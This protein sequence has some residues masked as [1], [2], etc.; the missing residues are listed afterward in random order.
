MARVLEGLETGGGSKVCLLAVVEGECACGNMQGMAQ[1]SRVDVPPGKSFFAV[2]PPFNLNY[3]DAGRSHLK[4]SEACL[5]SVVFLC[6][7]FSPCFWEG[8][9]P[10]FGGDEPQSS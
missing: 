7:F 6:L 4:N 8:G 3:V 10:P 2:I 5:S 9:E 1:P